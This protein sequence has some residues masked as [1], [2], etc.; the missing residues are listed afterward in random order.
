[1]PPAVLQLT[2][3]CVTIRAPA[4]EPQFFAAADDGTA[5]ATLARKA[6]AVASPDLAVGPL[7]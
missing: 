4:V 7:V 3:P 2:P 6:I 5:R 1:M